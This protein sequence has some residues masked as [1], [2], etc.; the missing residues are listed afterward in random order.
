MAGEAWDIEVVEN[1]V[2]VT[3]AAPQGPAGPTGAT[4]PAGGEV[5]ITV[6]TEDPS[7]GTDGD[8]WFKVSS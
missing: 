7:G 4:G 2:Q 8:L 6:S 5:N 3:L 1:I